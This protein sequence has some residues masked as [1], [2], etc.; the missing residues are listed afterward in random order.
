MQ[1]AHVSKEKKQKIAAALKTVMPKGWKWSLAVNN[2]STIVLTIASA[3]VDLM[4]EAMRVHN[5]NSYGAGC[6]GKMTQPETHIQAN[7]RPEMYFDESLE[8]F[9]KIRDALNI[10]NYDNSDSQ[11]DYFDVGHY[12]RLNLG[13]W[14]KPFIVK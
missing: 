14:N 3:P 11:T 2:S 7:C 1:M 9:R 8:L 12:V 13:S 5:N 4:A 10:D 6:D